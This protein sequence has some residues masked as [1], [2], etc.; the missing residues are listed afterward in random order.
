MARKSTP[1]RGARR[2]P[3]PARATAR[4]SVSE[5][6]R[7][8]MIA[9][10]MGLLAENPFEQIGL[11]DVASRAGFSLSELRGEF[12]SL[13]GILGAHIKEIDRIVLDGV[14]PELAEE[15]A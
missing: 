2:R 6:P 1:K 8:R 12:S 9:A 7:D 3:A 13:L 10:F 11:A 14:D 4:A 15:P 5:T